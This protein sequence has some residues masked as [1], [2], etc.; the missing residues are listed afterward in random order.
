MRG[1]AIAVVAVASVMV[2]MWA[3]SRGPE[4]RLTQDLP[5]AADALVEETWSQFLDAFPAQR[6][7]LTDVEV[8]A[9][10]ELDGA[11]AAYRRATGVIRIRIPTSPARFPESLA[12][13]LGHHL[14]TVCDPVGDVGDRFLLA[15]GFPPAQEWYTGE[16]WFETPS[17]HFAEAVVEVTR[18]ERIVHAADIELSSAAVDVVRSWGRSSD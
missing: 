12:H 7:C 13:E 9:V 6:D 4:I 10:R 17:E 15:Q 11:D 8:L 5:A 1:I 14:E 16:T 18:G 2:A 3:T